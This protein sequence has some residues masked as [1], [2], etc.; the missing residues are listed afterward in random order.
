LNHS[1]L[2][3]G[4]LDNN[5]MGQSSVR[6]IRS[7][8]VDD[9]S[10]LGTAITASTHASRNILPITGGN[11]DSL[12]QLNP[13]LGDEGTS[14]STMSVRAIRA[15]TDG[16]SSLG[17]A[18]TA[19]T[20]S[21]QGSSSILLPI[22]GGTIGSILMDPTLGEP[23]VIADSVRAI[24]DVD[25]DADSS[26]GTNITVAT[27]GSRPVVP[28]VGGGNLDSILI[29][30]P[31]S[32]SDGIRESIRATRGDTDGNSSLGT[33]FTNSTMTSTIATST[34]VRPDAIRGRQRSE[35]SS[36]LRQ[37]VSIVLESDPDLSRSRSNSPLTVQSY[38]AGSDAPSAT[39]TAASQS[40]TILS[41]VAVAAPRS[42]RGRS[43]LLRG[44]S[45]GTG[46]AVPI[47]DRVV[48]FSSDLMQNEQLQN[49]TTEALCDDLTMPD[50]LD[51]LSEVADIFSTS[52]R[53][54]RED[55]EARLDALQ[56]RLANE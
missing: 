27:L 4:A 43:S 24:R 41:S 25:A 51:N 47:R 30:P 37:R 40:A 53:A 12:L 39:S 45:S 34:L 9:N 56:K 33:C 1:S 13:E 22:S 20:Q 44:D 21:T 38:T 49:L 54:W 29:D 2:S 17:T 14:S 52:A 46:D 6:A 10:S 32:E 35:E 7:G 31:I 42:G 18:F 55:Y 48:S 16:N 36:N 15:D 19:V 11:L 3:E 50:E 28:I 23:S 8:D 26:I 5:T